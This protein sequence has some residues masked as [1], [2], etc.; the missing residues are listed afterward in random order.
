MS[1]DEKYLNRDIERMF[2]ERVDVLN[3]ITPNRVAP[4]RAV[5]RIL[6]KG[7]TERVRFRILT[8]QE[9]LQLQL[10]LHCLRRL[11][12]SLLDGAEGSGVEMLMEEAVTLTSDRVR[13]TFDVKN[14]VKSA[15]AEYVYD[16]HL[17]SGTSGS[18][19]LLAVP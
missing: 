13:E 6:A 18:S 8:V 3:V 7:F 4:M 2:R 17:K 12:P 9:A 11:V 1:S 19:N 5:F 15:L 10:D 14:R 16:A